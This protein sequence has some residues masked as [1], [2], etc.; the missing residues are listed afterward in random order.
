MSAARL[1]H[2]AKELTGYAP[3]SVPGALLV[4][5]LA[6]PALTPAFKE[7]TLGLKPAKLPSAPV[8]SASKK[9]IFRAAGKYKYVREEI[10]EAPVLEEED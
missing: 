3:W 9:D 7:E 6:W 2:Y 8:A 5:Y 10:G 1:T 4:G